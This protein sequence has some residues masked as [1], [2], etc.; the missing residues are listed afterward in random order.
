MS[1]EAR[2]SLVCM[3]QAFQL[4]QSQVEVKSTQFL[5]Q[6]LSVP[7]T[8]QGSQA[9]LDGL[10]LGPCPYGIYGIFQEVVIND[11]RGLTHCCLPYMYR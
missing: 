5:S 6:R 8:N 4:I 3:P 9:C 11:D 7:L 10:P 1:L 2:E